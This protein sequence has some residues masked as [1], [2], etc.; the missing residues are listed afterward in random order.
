MKLSVGITGGAGILGTRFVSYLR[1]R[2][3][4]IRSLIGKLPDWPDISGQPAEF[5]PDTFKFLPLVI[6]NSEKENLIL[7]SGGEKGAPFV[8]IPSLHLPVSGKMM[9]NNVIW[10]PEKGLDDGIE[11]SPEWLKGRRSVS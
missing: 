7:V 2:G 5:C 11:N 8:C 9:M 3:F 4:R 10:V 1:E 6:E